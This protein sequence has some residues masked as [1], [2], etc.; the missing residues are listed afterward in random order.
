[1]NGFLA[2]LAISCRLHLRNR[3]ALIYGYLFPL[4]FLVVFW[5]LYR[6][7]TVPLLRH[8]GEL[9]TVTILGGACFGLPTTL[10]SE[11]EGTRHSKHFEG[12]TLTGDKAEIGRA[13]V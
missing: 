5:V 1:M 4:V 9:L 8:L 13:H 10:V 3:M 7:E 2:H 6:H 12:P 11:R